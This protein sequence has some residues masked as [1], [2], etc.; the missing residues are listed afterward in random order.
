MT[1]MTCGDR[2][3]WCSFFDLNLSNV[4]TSNGCYIIFY[5]E[6][7]YTSVVYVGSSE[8]SIANRLA[9]HRTDSRINAYRS[10]GLL[11]TWAPTNALMREGIERYLADRYKPLVGDAHPNVAP[12]PIDL[13]F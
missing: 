5:K 11:V 7:P 4:I 6:L 3:F 1:W 13:P 8:R 2:N 12:I 10:K 9:E